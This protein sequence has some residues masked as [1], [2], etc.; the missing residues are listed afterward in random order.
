MVEYE[1]YLIPDDPTYKPDADRIGRLV[2]ALLENRYVIASD[3]R[4]SAGKTFDRFSPEYYS[5]I[6]TGCVVQLGEYAF[7]RFPCPCPTGDVTA[8]ADRDF[9]L[10]WTNEDLAESPSKYPMS[11][12]VDENSHWD[13]EI[14]VP[15]R[16]YVY[17][18]T[19]IIQPF[20]RKAACRCGQVLEYDKDY[21]VF[22]DRRISRACP[23]CGEPFRPRDYTLRLKNVRTGEDL[24]PRPGGAL[25]LFAILI[26]CGK[27]YDRDDLPRV[28]DEFLGLCEESIGTPLFQFGDCP[29]C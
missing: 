1:H 24:G 16:D 8:L 10:I 17:P 6:E 5:A 27:C 19:T 13:I 21:F 9:R 25:Y 22:A 12:I 14:H 26:D 15:A 3:A 4:E 18:M 11:K 29:G 20:E 23:I 2:N 28:S 7:A